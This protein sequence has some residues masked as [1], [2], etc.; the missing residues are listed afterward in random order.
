MSEQYNELTKEEAYVI[1]RKGTERAGTGEYE[2]LMDP[3]TYICRQCNAAIFTS[4][5]KFA[6]HCGW[7]S[8]DDEI[9]GSVRRQIDADG[10]RTEILCNNCDGHLG[11]VFEGEQYTDKNVRHCVNSISMKFIPQGDELPARIVISNE[12]PEP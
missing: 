6:S 3:G 5:H 1:L 4:E 11:H 2:L 9:E 10:R 7:P 12:T 8:F